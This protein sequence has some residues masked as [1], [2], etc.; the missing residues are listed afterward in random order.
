MA[1]VLK[2]LFSNDKA[3]E[4]I[5]VIKQP[6]KVSQYQGT[7]N[8]GKALVVG[9]DG[10]VGYGNAGMT[11]AQKNA[12][13][14]CI[15]YVSWA[16]AN[17]QQRYDALYNAL[18]GEENLYWNFQWNASSR[19]IPVGMTYASEFTPEFTSDGLHVLRPNIVFDNNGQDCE[20]EI[21]M[22][23][24]THR[25]GLGAAGPSICISKGASP[26]DPEHTNYA[27]VRGLKKD[28]SNLWV[29]CGS[30]EIDSGMTQD[31]FHIINLTLLDGNYYARI[32]GVLIDSGNTGVSRPDNNYGTGININYNAKA[33]V[34]INSI[35]YR[36]IV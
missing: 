24:D 5:N 7:V 19:Q 34:Y 25:S 29:N 21:I 10:V 23:Y 2:Q 36:A 4:L 12:L 20:L 26:E 35:K 14:D 6:D 16:D 33:Y 18:F 3:D 17:G 30:G 9:R 15:R 11:D 27:F 22:K 28:S 32:D 13:L 8:A 31:D 1:E